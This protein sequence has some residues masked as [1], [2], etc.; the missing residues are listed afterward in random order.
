VSG[1]ERSR[2][3]EADAGG[4]YAAGRLFFQRQTTLFSQRF[5]PDDDALFG[6]PTPVAEDAWLNP[7][8]DGLAAFAVARDGRLAYRRGGQA[9]RRLVWFDR[10]GRSLRTVGEAGFIASPAL[11]TDER[12]IVASRTN[13]N[14][15]HLL[16]LDD[17]NA[18]GTVITPSGVN[19]STPLFSPDGSQI[20]YGDDRKGPFDLYRLKVAEPG[21]DAPLLLTPWWKYAETWSPDGRFIVYTE[22]HPTSRSNLWVLPTAADAKPYAFLATP[23]AESWARF[24]PDGR[25][26]AYTS[27]ESGREDVFVQPFPPTGAKWQ[28][29]AAGGSEPAWRGDGRE[30]FYVGPDFRLMSVTVTPSSTVLAFGP[31]RALFK[32][33]VEQ[34]TVTG[35]NYAVSRD[36]QSVLVVEQQ[37]AATSSPVVVVV[38]PDASGGSRP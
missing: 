38:G 32:I 2:L 34:T 4:G 24:S 19:A 7:N 11:S 21:K 6:E 20:V 10:E 16:L 37:G 33:P 29:S 31:P 17:A 36:G 18:A 26:L 14:D 12:S 1:L 22:V 23:A 25:F 5:D 15:S 9:A 27:D 30:M 13:Q 3:V 28:V 35:R 8:Q